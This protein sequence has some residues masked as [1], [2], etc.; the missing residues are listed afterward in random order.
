[1]NLLIRQVQSCSHSRGWLY[2]A[3]SVVRPDAFPAVRCEDWEAFRRG[4][5]EKEV[6]YVRKYK[7]AI[8][9]SVYRAKD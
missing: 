6:R 5:C 1:M 4:R 7:I 2:Y 9:T 8:I 3:E